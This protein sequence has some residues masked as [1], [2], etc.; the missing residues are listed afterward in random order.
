MNHELPDVQAGLRKGRG[1]R[2]QITNIHSIIEKVREFQKNI[3]FCFIDYA[4][5]FDC[6]DHNKVWKILQEMG[7]PD[8]LNGLLRKRYAGKEATVRITHGKTDWFQIG[9]V[10]HQGCMLL[11]CLFNLHEDYMMR[12]PGLNKEQAEIKMVGRN[13]NNLRYTDDTT[14]M[15]ESEELKILLMRVK[16][17]SETLG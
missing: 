2:D 15:A 5:V 11:V 8:H 3:C 17:E 10:V 14:L 7:I 16:E 1:S 9:K 12:N 6:L 13:V 4:K